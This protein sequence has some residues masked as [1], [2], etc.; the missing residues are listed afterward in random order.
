MR[1]KIALES[2]DRSICANDCSV[3]DNM[4]NHIT[5]GLQNEFQAEASSNLK[6]MPTKCNHE[7]WLN[8][9]VALIRG[10]SLGHISEG[11]RDFFSSP[12]LLEDEGAN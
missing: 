8:L 2:T 10:V 11:E 5:T 9:A 12:S 6:N 4:H 1:R 3:C 7:V